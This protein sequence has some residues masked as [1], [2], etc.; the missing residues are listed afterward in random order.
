MS[1]TKKTTVRVMGVDVFQATRQ[2]FNEVTQRTQYTGVSFIL[3]ELQPFNNKGV[4][5]ELHTNGQINIIETLIHTKDVFVKSLHTIPS[6][7]A[8]LMESTD[9]ASL[10]SSAMTVWARVGMNISIPHER[11]DEFERNPAAFIK[12]GFTDGTCEL[13]GELYFP[14]ELDEN[15]N[16]AFSGMSF[17]L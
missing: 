8:Q 1:K 17:D 13:S 7:M 6:F 16:H 9:T 14:E 4:T 5:V 3:P 2:E 15:Q 12:K 10:E 11:A